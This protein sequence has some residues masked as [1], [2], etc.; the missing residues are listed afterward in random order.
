MVVGEISKT[1]GCQVI[2]ALKVQDLS[3]Q[4]PLAKE[5][6]PWEVKDMKRFG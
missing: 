5:M 1:E 3:F 6:W 4:L 2:V